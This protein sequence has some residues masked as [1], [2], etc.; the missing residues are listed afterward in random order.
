[1]AKIYLIVP[2]SK[3]TNRVSTAIVD[4]DNLPQGATNSIVEEWSEQGTEIVLWF[5]SDMDRTRRIVG[6]ISANKINQ[7][8]VD[9]I[10]KLASFWENLFPGEGEKDAVLGAFGDRG[11]FLR[12]SPEVALKIYN[13]MRTGQRPPEL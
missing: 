10:S 11:D 8:S 7:E 13:A 4:L 2:D 6:N 9:F 5:K 1:M 3:K 12:T